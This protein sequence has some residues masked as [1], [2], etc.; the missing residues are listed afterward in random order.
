MSLVRNRRS[1][2][3]LGLTALLATVFT[4]AF[5]ATPQAQVL[6]NPRIAEFDPSPDHWMVLDSGE[7][8]VLAYELEVYLIGASNPFTTVGM[9]K[10]SPDTDGK[11]RYD[12]ASGVAGWPVSG[13]TFEARVSAVG[14]EGAALSEPSNPFTFTTG[15]TCAITL[16]V[17]TAPIAASG[18][19][20]DV[21][22]YAGPGCAW[23]ATTTL[24]WVTMG[25][26]AGSGIGT[27]SFAVQVNSSSSSRTGTIEIGGQILTVWQAGAV[28]AAG[29]A[30]AAC[31]YTVSPTY[32]S[33][34]AA[35]G[36]GVVSVATGAGCAWTLASSDHWL[37]PTVTKGEGS[38]GVTF[39]AQPNNG[40]M[41]R[42]AK[43]SVGPWSI[44]V[45]QRGKLHRTK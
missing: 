28:G 44:W 21:D 39:T 3:L 4:L 19:A 5:A 41:G 16:S 23:A 43:L 38:A 10:P 8:A 32:F 29:A 37:V 30:G 18:G 26:G 33:M 13:A 34:P 6:S 31:S 35:G 45:S 24:S 25:T 40:M 7:P 22:V 12:F 1:S 9:G 17:T 27:V 20:F 2:A 36:N 15:S 11:I 14:P 42:T